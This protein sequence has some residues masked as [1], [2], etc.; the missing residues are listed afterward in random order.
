MCLKEEQ[1]TKCDTVVYEKYILG[2]LD[3]Q[4]VFLIYIW[5]LSVVLAHSS[6]N[7]WDFLSHRVVGA[8]LGGETYPQHVEVPRLGIEPAPQQ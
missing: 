4:N 8:S 1:V 6:P 3:D 5:S 7:S 2:R